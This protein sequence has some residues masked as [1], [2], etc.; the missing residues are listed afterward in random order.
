MRAFTI[1]TPNVSTPVA[2]LIQPG[3]FVDV[4]LMVTARDQP[5]GATSRVLLHRVEVLAVDQVVDSSDAKAATRDTR[6]VT[7]LVSSGDALKLDLGQSLG[8]L[9]LVLRNPGDTT[10]PE[11]RGQAT[12]ED[13]GFPPPRKPAP[14]KLPLPAIPVEQPS[15]PTPPPQIRL[16]RGSYEGVV[17][18][19]PVAPAG[20][21]RQEEGT[22]DGQR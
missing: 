16:L 3:H 6:S 18:L 10:L 20:G 1:Q 7:L 9:H 17:Q 11:A 14:E 4:L 8:K 13:L 19:A 5:G 2:G 15:A 21:G 12:P 22:S